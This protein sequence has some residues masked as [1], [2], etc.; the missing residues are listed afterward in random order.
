MLLSNA[1]KR[2]NREW[3]FR[4]LN[5]EFSAGKSYAIIGPNGSGKSTLL[6]TLG[7]SMEMSEGVIQWHNKDLKLEGEHVHKYISIS[8]PSLELI[9]EF[10]VTEFLRF[11]S[12]FKPFLPGITISKI[13]SII[14]LEK[15]ATKQI[16]YY[17]SGMKQRV[18]LA[19]AIFADT[20]LLLLDEPC[21][22]MDAAGYE[23]YHHLIE[24]YCQGKTIILSSNDENEYSFCSEVIS[25]MEYK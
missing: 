20:T 3:I 25:I 9:E 13:L 24:N 14:G 16:R 11:H 8:T 21:T 1:G 7:G 4:N 19:Q 22:N 15:A 2:F 18:K 12:R 10:T 6:Q 23:L 5:Y 17:S